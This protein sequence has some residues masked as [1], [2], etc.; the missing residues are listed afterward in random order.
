[1]IAA[2]NATLY[3]AA[4]GKKLLAKVTLMYVF[5]FKNC[6]SNFLE[7]WGGVQLNCE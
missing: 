5:L 6:D 2:Y 7:Q 4:W 1:M 3:N